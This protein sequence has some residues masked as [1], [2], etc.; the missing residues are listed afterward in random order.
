M[1]KPSQDLGANVNQCRSYGKR[2]DSES[3]PAEAGFPQAMTVHEHLLLLFFWSSE[4]SARSYHS[5]A[6]LVSLR[7]CVRACVRARAC[8]RARVRFV[9]ERVRA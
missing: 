4:D 1:A 9:R 5:G 3:A 8:A 2:R 6:R 7:V